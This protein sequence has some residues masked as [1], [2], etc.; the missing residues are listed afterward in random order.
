MSG[1]KQK[2]E[3]RVK[4]GDKNFSFVCGDGYHRT[5]A[6]GDATKVLENLTEPRVIKYADCKDNMDDFFDYIANSF[7]YEYNSIPKDASTVDKL[8]AKCKMLYDYCNQFQENGLSFSQIQQSDLN[9]E[10]KYFFGRK[11]LV[12]IMSLYSACQYDIDKTIF[13]D[14]YSKDERIIN[15]SIEMAA[16]SAMLAIGSTDRRVVDFL[17][18]ENY[19]IGKEVVKNTQN[20]TSLWSKEDKQL[21]NEKWLPDA[22]NEVYS[23]VNKDS[24]ENFEEIK[25]LK[26][27]TENEKYDITNRAKRGFVANGVDVT[28]HDECIY[29]DKEKR[30]L[31]VFY[32]PVNIIER[33]YDDI[34]LKNSERVR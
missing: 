8:T 16:C 21:Y 29:A 11:A 20:V 24:I 14:I 27:M 28:E 4:V 5:L 23:N 15:N 13:D 1:K 6:N 2:I 22:E 12:C 7:F 3:Y 18:S 25:N 31:G 19:H 26:P 33:V 9:S 32:T 17:R 10:D 34:N 30:V